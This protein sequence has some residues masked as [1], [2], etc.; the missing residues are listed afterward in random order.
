MSHVV[1]PS[2]LHAISSTRGAGGAAT[3]PL[4][5]L[6]LLLLHSDTTSAADLLIVVLPMK[7]QRLRPLTPQMMLMR[8][9]GSIGDSAARQCSYCATNAMIRM[10]D[11]GDAPQQQNDTL[12]IRTW[13][14]LLQ[15][16]TAPLSVCRELQ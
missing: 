14:C 11:G 6:L 12:C 13:L 7:A 1:Y 8:C 15:P 4:A 9:A 5:L 16:R 3:K 2:G 10:V